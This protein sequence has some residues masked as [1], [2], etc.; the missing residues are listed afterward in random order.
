MYVYVCVCV[1]LTFHCLILEYKGEFLFLVFS[2]FKNMFL[3][4]HTDVPIVFLPDF[5]LII[6][7]LMQVNYFKEVCATQFHLDVTLKRWL[8]QKNQ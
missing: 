4:E 2:I 3:S 1:Y 6:G 5:L 8:R 7:K